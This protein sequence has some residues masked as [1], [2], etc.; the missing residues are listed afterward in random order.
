[1]KFRDCWKEALFEVG[2]KAAEANWSLPNSAS[3][4]PESGR[5][6]HQHY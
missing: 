4:A 1:M 6:K 2:D 5:N 3:A